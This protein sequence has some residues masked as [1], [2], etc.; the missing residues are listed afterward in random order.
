MCHCLYVH[1]FASDLLP[2]P[3]WAFIGTSVNCHTFTH[4]NLG[5]LSASLSICCSWNC[6]MTLHSE[7]LSGAQLFTMFTLYSK[8]KS[9]SRHL[10]YSFF[11]DANSKVKRHDDSFWSIV[12]S[13]IHTAKIVSC[14][15]SLFLSSHE[16]SKMHKNTRTAINCIWAWKHHEREKQKCLGD[17]VGD[18]KDWAASSFGWTSAGFSSELVL[19]EGCK[20]G[21][22]VESPRHPLL[23]LV[24]RLGRSSFYFFNH[25]G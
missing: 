24:T 7:T 21:E 18:G 20:G 5:T 16:S 10:C 17:S 4:S 3:H 25:H 14:L 9:S 19:D 1:F 6:W 15:R 22:H 12:Q 2:S 11:M 23:H 13:V 8:K